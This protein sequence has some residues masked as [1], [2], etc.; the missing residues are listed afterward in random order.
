MRTEA[1]AERPQ[2]SSPRKTASLL[3][4]FPARVSELVRTDYHLSHAKRQT[5]QR[6]KL[7]AETNVDQLTGTAMKN[8]QAIP[9]AM[10]TRFFKTHSN[11]LPSEWHSSL[12]MARGCGSIVQSVKSQD[13][14]KRNYLSAHF[15]DITHPDDLERDVT[16]AKKMLDWRN[17]HVSHGETLL[18]Q[19]RLHRLGDVERLLGSR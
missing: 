2:T 16:N 10:Q 18:P 5:A 11:T 6:Y 4:R 15:Q 1:R 3:F 12:P 8:P 7:V 13:I 14:P 19:E 9:P 17:R